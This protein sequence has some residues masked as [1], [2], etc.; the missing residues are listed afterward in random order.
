M[1]L[2]IINRQIT[3]YG[4]ELN[5]M[6]FR[7]ISKMNG[8]DW[9]NQRGGIYILYSDQMM[10]DENILLQTAARVHLIGANG[11]LGSQMPHYSI[12]VHHLPTFTPTR[13]A[14][15]RSKSIRDPYTLAF[16]QN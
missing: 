8:E 5:G 12:Q 3:D 2:V 6:L 9:L 1:D 15:S 10:Q 16:S 11:S 13:Q 4:A 7:M 14:V